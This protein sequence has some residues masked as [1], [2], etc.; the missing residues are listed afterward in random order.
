MRLEGRLVHPGLAGLEHVLEGLLQHVP[1]VIV[2]L[3]AF[4][5]GDH[6]AL[7]PAL[8]EHLP[9]R[10]QVLELLEDRLPLFRV[11]IGNHRGHRNA[12]GVLWPPSALCNRSGRERLDQP[13]V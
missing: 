8:F 1:A 10:A 7:E 12:R 9:Q 6:D 11:H 2:V 4:G 3:A 5:A 13:D